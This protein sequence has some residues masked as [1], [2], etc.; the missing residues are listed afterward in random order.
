MKNGRN[1]IATVNNNYVLITLIYTFDSTST[2]LMCFSLSSTILSIKENKKRTLS[3]SQQKKKS[4]AVDVEVLGDIHIYF[5]TLHFA[6][7][8]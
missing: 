5:Y 1:G 6:F 3:I 7:M 4:T 2:P 8:S